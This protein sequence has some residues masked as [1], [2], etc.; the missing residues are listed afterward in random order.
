MAYQILS[1]LLDIATGLLGGACLLRLYMQHQRIPFGNPVGRLIFALTDWLVLP[2]RRVVRSVGRWDL[3]S[4]VAVFLL[5]LAQFTLLWLIAGGTVH[6]GGVLV[7]AVFG[8]ARLAVSGITA[9]L[10][11]AVILSWVQSNSPL[12]S[13]VERLAAPILRPFRRMIPLVG[14]IDLSPLAVLVLLQVAAM[15]LAELQRQV[16]L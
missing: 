7:L 6:F 10:V 3:A 12:A 4:L 16:L 5:E 15:V 9:L 2:L 1:F 14:G 13:I 8:V 11:V